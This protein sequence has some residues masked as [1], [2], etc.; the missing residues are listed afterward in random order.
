MAGVKNR[1]DTRRAWGHPPR[2]KCAAKKS[3]VANQ[4]YD[5]SKVGDTRQSATALRM[6]GA[7]PDEEEVT[8]LKKPSISWV[9]VKLFLRPP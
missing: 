1:S 7:D 9:N 2:L 8:G 6:K 4:E 5:D 3:T